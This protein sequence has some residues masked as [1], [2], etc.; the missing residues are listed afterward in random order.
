LP[1]DMVAFSIHGETD[2]RFLNS[3]YIHGTAR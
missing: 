2:Q 3:N 1:A